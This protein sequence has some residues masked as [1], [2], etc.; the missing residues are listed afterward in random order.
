M[1]VNNV[2]VSSDIH[3][4]SCLDVNDL[5]DQQYRYRGIK[6]YAQSKLLMNLSSFALAHRLRNVNTR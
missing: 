4:W 3:R 2:N 1:K 6:A 5:Q